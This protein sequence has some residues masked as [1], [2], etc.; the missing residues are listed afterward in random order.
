MFSG[1]SAVPF[2]TVF[3]LDSN[4]LTRGHTAKIKKNICRTDL[5]K[6]F[7]SQNVSSIDGIA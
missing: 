6:H 2:E 3:Q 5:R 1:I 4:N 7:S